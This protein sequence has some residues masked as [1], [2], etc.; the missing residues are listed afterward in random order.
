MKSV[1]LILFGCIKQR[2][3]VFMLISLVLSIVFSAY[4]AVVSGERSLRQAVSENTE[5]IHG[6]FDGL[7]INA[8]KQIVTDNRIEKVGE[9]G[10]YAISQIPNSNLKPVA[11]GWVD[12]IAVDLHKIRLIEGRFPKNE[13]EIAV[14]RW[15]LNELK[16]DNSLEKELSFSLRLFTDGSFSEEHTVR[17]FLVVGVLENYAQ[18]QGK[19]ASAWTLPRDGYEQLPNVL[20]GK[21]G[22]GQS[23]KHYSVVLKIRSNVDTVLIQINEDINAELVINEQIAFPDIYN[24]Q[25]LDQSIMGI[26]SVVI[27]SCGFI[28]IFITTYLY[29]YGFR[30]TV[31]IYAELGATSTSRFA[32]SFSQCFSLHLLSVPTGAIIGLISIHILGVITNEVFGITYLVSITLEDM[33]RSYVL[34]AAT[35][36]FSSVIISLVML[37]KKRKKVVKLQRGN[38][39]YISVYHLFA[40]KEAVYKFR[41]FVLNMFM[42]LLCIVTVFMGDIILQMVKQDQETLYCD[43]SLWYSGHAYVSPIMIPVGDKIGFTENEIEP[44]VNDHA[45]KRSI[46]VKKADM[47]FVY[48][49]DDPD[50]AEFVRDDRSIYGIDEYEKALAVFDFQQNTILEMVEVA[51]VNEEVYEMIR[52]KSPCNTVIKDGIIICVTE[53]FQDP[54]YGRMIGK[55]LDFSRLFVD[56]DTAIA[57]RNDYQLDVIDYIVVQKKEGML[58]QAMYGVSFLVSNNMLETIGLDLPCYGVY[59]ELFN[60]EEA[61]NID[62]E[63]TSLLERIPEAASTSLRQLNT[64]LRKQQN[65]I[66]VICNS[67]VLLVIVMLFGNLLIQNIYKIRSRIDLY[68]RIAAIGATKRHI[69]IIILSEYFMIAFVAYILSILLIGVVIILFVPNALPFIDMD[70][71]VLNQAVILMVLALYGLI[72][73]IYNG[74]WLDSQ[75]FI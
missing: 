12:E 32:F 25:T 18:I 75:V 62:S 3:G 59:L 11:V 73:T 27:W 50:L 22:D 30:K 49:G 35:T 39:K 64:E 63:M 1:L 56:Q 15:V 24:N 7:F 42:L 46:I 74:K 31:A 57:Q 29:C 71:V 13:N 14:E 5:R 9:L 8:Q 26:L 55:K 21:H 60:P 17:K 23:V 69:S 20:C 6:V 34:Y 16:Y 43:Y 58:Y 10:V 38:I 45:V 36:L 61:G 28:M 37:C 19:K 72:L 44:F 40:Y 41:R 65:M 68:R 48:K 51:S 70:P 33:L 52:D 47:H 4:I 67:I 53:E 54:L 66:Q 2:L